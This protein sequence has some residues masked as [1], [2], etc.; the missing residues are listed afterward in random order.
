MGI[1][2]GTSGWRAIIA[3]EFTLANVRLVTSAIASVLDEEAAGGSV[4]I[5]YDTR[6][7]S[8]R[9]AAECATEF[10]GLGF[11]SYLTTRETPTPT[12]SHAI[13]TIGARGGINFTASHNPPHYNGMKFSTADGAPALPEVTKK[14]EGRIAEFQSGRYGKPERKDS[15]EALAL[16][17]R[18][19]Y[20]TALGARVDF[21]KIASAR[22]ELAYDPLW[23]TGRGYLD[24][25]LRRLGRQVYTVHDYRD[26]LFGGRSPEPSEENL[27]EMRQLV[28]DKG[29]SLGVSTDGD[30]DRFGFIDRDGS[31][32]SANHILALL[33][34]YLCETRPEWAGGVARSVATTHL[35]DRVARRRRRQ[36][37]ETPVGFKFIG[38]LINQDK[39]ILGGEESAGLTVKGH[40]PEKDGILA[41][42]LVIEMVASRGASLGEM[43]EELFRKDGALYSERVGI[44][45]TPEVKDRLQKRL[46]SDPPN[47]IGGRRVAEV[48]RM[49][50][51]K[52]IFDDGSWILLRM[53]GTEPVVRCYA[54]TNT[55]QDLEVLI[56][57][58]S[59]FVLS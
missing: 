12:L 59:K 2:F 43:L 11:E 42:L 51:V 19:D 28:L 32:I 16:D 27:G 53:S 33:L 49:D 13:R 31:F 21:A 30:A 44:K 54:E 37:Y 36:V 18:E 29:L 52:Y 20:L 17:P 48:N 22:L 5:G 57:T 39:L 4:I 46:S 56:E 15:A 9:F 25:V 8:E 6:F 55:K 41:C 50:G 24:E 23:G 26:V 35:L 38:E 14:I 34:D 7:L 45:L 58:G 47:S 3:D 40:F 1:T 10:A